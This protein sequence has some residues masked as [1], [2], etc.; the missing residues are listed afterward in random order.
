MQEVYNWLLTNWRIVLEVVLLI[1]SVL[2]ALFRKKPTEAI[3]TAIYI[4]CVNAINS[5]ECT[6]LKGKQKLEYA[7]GFVNKFLQECYPG[8]NV[9]SHYGTIVRTIEEI[10]S[11]PQKKGD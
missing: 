9:G 5:A 4:G 7:V 10:L 1:V 2:I 8:I 11:T 3:L 6:K